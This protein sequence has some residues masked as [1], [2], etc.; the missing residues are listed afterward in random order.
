MA[1]V[2]AMSLSAGSIRASL[3]VSSIVSISV[4]FVVGVSV[5][6]PFGGMGKS[7][8]ACKRPA[9]AT[10]TVV[11]KAPVQPTITKA[12]FDLEKFTHLME[13]VLGATEV[14]TQAPNII[15][16][17]GFDGMNTVGRCID[18]LFGSDGNTQAFGA[19]MSE[20]SAAFALMCTNPGHV[21]KDRFWKITVTAHSKGNRV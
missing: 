20:S 14:A 10:K 16:A 13:Q 8:A 9:A 6:L 15:W 21:F 7:S 11:K 19:E 17:S 2:S 1:S 3:K 12:A 18:S 4:W 5:S